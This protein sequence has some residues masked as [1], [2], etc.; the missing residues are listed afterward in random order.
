MIS[1]KIS[2]HFC[3]KVAKINFKSELLKFQAQP[4]FLHR[5]ISKEAAFIRHSL[6]ILEV[7]S[8]K[9]DLQNILRLRK[10]YHES[11]HFISDH[12]IVQHFH[13]CPYPYPF[14]YDRDLRPYRVKTPLVSIY[15]I[16]EA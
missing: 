12:L 16:S 8:T 15:V 1:A 10:S 7:R 6:L 4:V 14:L 3:K 13:D 11:L 2:T 5:L 9:N